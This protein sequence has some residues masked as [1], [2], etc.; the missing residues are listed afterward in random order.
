MGDRLIEL[1]DVEVTYGRV[2]AIEQIDLVVSSSGYIGIVGPSGSG[3]STLLKVMA[4]G[5]RPGRG[6]VERCEGLRIG[7]VPQVDLINWYFPVSVREVV[8]M[9]SD[10]GRLLPWPSRQSSER[11]DALLAALGLEGMEDRP[12]RSLS[13]GQQQRAFIARA[14]MGKPQLL[15][16]DEPVSGVDVAT[17]HDVLHLLHDLNHDENIA[18]VITTHDINGIA[19]HM[20]QLICLNR[21]IVE[22]GKP[23]EVLTREVLEAT[24]G[25]SME[26]L[27][28]G[29]MPVVIE[30]AEIGLSGPH[31]DHDPQ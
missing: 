6:N 2:I 7:Y 13:G 24:Y 14:L 20:H 19:A 21:R 27:S 18:I 29:G 4:G 3:K 15:L 8:L 9:S 10:R 16:L 11:C 25:A 22:S 17:R 28:H 1:R 31:H 26:V 23:A 30:K 5:L 12:V